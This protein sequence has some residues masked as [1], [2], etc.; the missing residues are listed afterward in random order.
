MAQNQTGRKWLSIC[1][2]ATLEIVNT[3]FWG[4]IFD[5]IDVTLNSV[6]NTLLCLGLKGHTSLQQ[7][8]IGEGGCC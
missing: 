8:L 4:V 1:P 7:V 2:S 3:V 5:Q 6:V